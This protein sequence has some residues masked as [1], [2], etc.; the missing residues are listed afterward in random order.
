MKRDLVY[1]FFIECCKY[2]KDRF[3]KNIFEDLAY[4]ITPYGTYINKDLLT[5]NFKDKEFVYKIQK[6]DPEEI[7]NEIYS[8]FS[9]K[10]SLMSREEIIKKK[11]DI[12]NTTN[13]ALDDWASIKKKNLKE[14]MIERYVIDMKNTFS[15]SVKQAKYLVSIIFLAFV[16]KVF[17]TSDVSVKD[18]KI[19]N[20]EGLD[21]VNGKILLIKNIYDIQV[22]ITPEIV[23][24][25][26][27]MSDEWE[28]FLIALK[29]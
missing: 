8:I 22:N 25:K 28:K 27:L 19:T 14:V 11:Q 9:L 18:G 1:P 12:G 2:A 10:M 21:Y 29:K 4:G 3:W 20:I 16:F 5:C 24:S 23:I 17:N 13:I 6:K 26:S 7:Y 15:L